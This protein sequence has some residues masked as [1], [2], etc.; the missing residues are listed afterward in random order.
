VLR[1]R[2]EEL[3]FEEIGQAYRPYRQVLT[4]SLGRWGA[5]RGYRWNDQD[6]RALVRSMESW[7]PFPDTVGA[8]RRVKEA[9]LRIWIVSNTDRSILAHTLRQMDVEFD[10]WTV[11]EEARAYKPSL[12]PFERA[13]TDIAEHPGHILHVAF[14]FKYDIPPAQRLGFRTGWL[15]RKREQRPGDEQ[16]D[17]EWDSLWGLADM[18]DDLA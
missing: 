2:W 18:A 3:Q 10:G 15:N 17:Y 12:K 9:G 11:A 16:P 13:I 4:D 8:L 5:E 1:E 14:G 7:Q 6:G